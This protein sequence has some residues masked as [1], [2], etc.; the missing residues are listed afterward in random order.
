MCRHLQLVQSTVGFPSEWSGPGRACRAVTPPRLFGAQRSSLQAARS[1]ELVPLLEF[2]KNV[3]PADRSRA[4][5]ANLPKWPGR[6][7]D[8]SAAASADGMAGTEPCPIGTTLQ[9]RCWF[10]PSG[11]CPNHPR[12]L[13]GGLPQAGERGP[14]PQHA[15]GDILALDIEGEANDAPVRALL[16]LE[17]HALGSSRLVSPMTSSMRSSIGSVYALPVDRLFSQQ[18]RPHRLLPARHRRAPG[19]GRADDHDYP[20]ASPTSRPQ[21]EM[22]SVES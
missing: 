11:R 8:R 16:N 9:E 19:T 1:D 20:V 13:A 12:R 5:A 17:F 3:R 4:R 6:V 21:E 10:Q 22:R 2:G 15:E 14:S 7:R 18:H